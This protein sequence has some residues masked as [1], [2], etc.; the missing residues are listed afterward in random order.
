MQI[1][2]K[3]TIGKLNEKELKELKDVMDKTINYV[4]AK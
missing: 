3:A 1:K 4:I 2:F